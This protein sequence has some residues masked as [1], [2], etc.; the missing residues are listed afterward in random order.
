LTGKGIPACKQTK[1]LA[2]M[3]VDDPQ[4][5]IYEFVVTPGSWSDKNFGW[6]RYA[7]TVG[8]QMIGSRPADLSDVVTR[9]FFVPGKMGIMGFE[10]L[11]IVTPEEAQ[12]MDRVP[13]DV[14]AKICGKLDR[15]RDPSAPLT[16]ALQQNPP[17]QM[18]PP[19]PP[20]A[21]PLTSNN[22]FGGSAMAQR[23]AAEPAPQPPAAR[24]RKSKQAEPV[25]PAPQAP[26]MPQQVNTP[27]PTPAPEQT[28]QIPGAPDDQLKAMMLSAFGIGKT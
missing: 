14:T 15:P 17:R 8:A 27:A 3:V 24:G 10:P 16:S 12:F 9:V 1:K 22:P 28:M 4:K 6:R 19:P 5:I 23:A 13:A 18:P 7:Q 21:S 25:A 20:A 26:F 11:R 2:V